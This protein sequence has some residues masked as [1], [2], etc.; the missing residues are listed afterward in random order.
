[1]HY[2]IQSLVCSFKFSL[3][4]SLTH[5][6]LLF[7]FICSLINFLN[8]SLSFTYALSLSCTHSFTYSPC[9]QISLQWLLKFWLMSNTGISKLNE[10]WSDFFCSIH[11]VSDMNQLL[12]KLLS[13]HFSNAK[14]I[15]YRWHS[16]SSLWWSFILWYL[17]G[18]WYYNLFVPLLTYVWSNYQN[19]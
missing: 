17:R 19:C 15:F 13:Q 1:M 3:S 10:H 11:M 6:F 4:V 7:H 9:S 5:H 2:L 12:H 18:S 14:R 16:F 8:L